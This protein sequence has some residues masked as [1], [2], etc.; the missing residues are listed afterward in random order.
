VGII[1]LFQDSSAH[2]LIAIKFFNRNAVQSSDAS[3][4]F[5]REID[6]LVLLVHPCVVRSVGNC[7]VTRRSPAQT[8]REF[9]AGGSLSDVL[10]RLDDTGK[11]IAGMGLALLLMFVHSRGVIR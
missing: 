10:R 2:D 6:T 5:I 9:A 3:T 7:L 4:A 11:P 1:K 8:G